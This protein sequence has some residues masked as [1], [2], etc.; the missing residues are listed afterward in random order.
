MNDLHSLGEIT[1]P[2]VVLVIID[3]GYMRFWSG[4]GD[5]VPPVEEFADPKMRVRVASS[6]DYILAGKDAAAVARLADFQNDL[7]VYDLPSDAMET[8]AAR[9]AHLAAEHGLDAPPLG[10]GWGLAEYRPR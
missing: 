8:V 3:M 5:P 7:H 1:C 2:A 9:V 10:E 6:A 4:R